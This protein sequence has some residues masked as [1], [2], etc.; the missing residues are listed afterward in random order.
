MSIWNEA[1]TQKSNRGPRQRADKNMF[2]NRWHPDRQAWQISIWCISQSWNFEKLHQKN[3][4]SLKHQLFSGW[5]EYISVQWNKLK[6][7]S[8][9]VKAMRGTDI[10]LKKYFFLQK[11]SLSFLTNNLVLKKRN[12]FLN[13]L[14]SSGDSIWP[15]EDLSKWWP[16]ERSLPRKPGKYLNV[17]PSYIICWHESI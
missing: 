11:L 4:S 5:A 1:R 7:V 10:G 9:Q 15:Y 3:K 6:T 14:T 17:L 8:A 2:G 13:I 16:K 12:S